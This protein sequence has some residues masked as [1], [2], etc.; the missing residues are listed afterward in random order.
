MS[1]SIPSFLSPTTV[2]T[3]DELI[4]KQKSGVALDYQQQLKIDRL[5]Q[6]MEELQNAMKEI[7]NV[8]L[9]IV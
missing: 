2:S 9:D 4:L 5:P 3:L 7:A 1:L 8:D 6:V